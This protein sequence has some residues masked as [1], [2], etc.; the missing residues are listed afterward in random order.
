LFLVGCYTGLRF[1]DLKNL[2]K[3]HIRDGKINLRVEKTEKSIV[4]PVHTIVSQIMKKYKESTP[5][6]LP[7]AIS[8]QKMN[9]YLKE[10]GIKAKIKDPIIIN[11][12]KGNMNVETK[13]FKYELICTHTARRS[14]ATNLYLSNFPTIEI[15]MIT[16]HRTESSFLRYI[17]MEGQQSASRLLE[18]W[19]KQTKLKKV[20]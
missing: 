10:I 18:H 14:F 19:A 11:E 13:K 5:N 1:S 15:R 16:G 6:S 4:I 3:D 7:P 9:G 17:K 20:V 12:I 8:N 2:K